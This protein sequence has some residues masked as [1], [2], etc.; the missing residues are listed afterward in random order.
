MMLNPPDFTS[1][2]P[3]DLYQFFF[4]LFLIFSVFSSTWQIKMLAMSF[5]EYT[6]ISCHTISHDYNQQL[7]DVTMGINGERIN[8]QSAQ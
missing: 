1:I 6:N 3:F 5:C 8:N 7:H 4:R 2:V